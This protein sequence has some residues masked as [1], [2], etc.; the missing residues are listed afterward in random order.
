M[1][2]N[3]A[4]ERARLAY[5]FGKFTEAERLFRDI[6][7]SDERDDAAA[8]FR[9]RAAIMASAIHVVQWDGVEHM[10]SK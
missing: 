2:T 8:Y 5:A 9:D 10:E 3:E 1:R 6:A 7:A 4:F